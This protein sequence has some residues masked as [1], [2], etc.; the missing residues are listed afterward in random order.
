MRLQASTTA[1]LVGNNDFHTDM[2]HA[3]PAAGGM[4]DAALAASISPWQR[5]LRRG[6]ATPPTHR[7]PAPPPPPPPALRQPPRVSCGGGPGTPAQAEARSRP[8]GGTLRAP[9]RTRTAPGSQSRPRSPHRSPR[10]AGRGEEGESCCEDKQ[11]RKKGVRAVWKQG[12][13]G[14]RRTRLTAVAAAAIAG[15]PPAH[16]RHKVLLRSQGPGRRRRLLLQL[17]PLVPCR[18]RQQ[19]QQPLGTSRSPPHMVAGAAAQPPPAAS[20]AASPAASHSRH[21]VPCRRCCM[22]KRAQA[23][24][25]TQTQHAPPQASL[26]RN[27]SPCPAPAR[28]PP[29]EQAL[30]SAASQPRSEA[31]LSAYLSRLCILSARHL[32]Y[33]NLRGGTG[34][35][36]GG[37]AVQGWVGGRYRLAGR[38]AGQV[39]RQA[40]YWA[41]QAANRVWLSGKVGGGSSRQVGVASQGRS[42]EV[43]LAHPGRRPA[44]S[45]QSSCLGWKCWAHRMWRLYLPSAAV[46]AWGG[47][48]FQQHVQRKQTS[49]AD[50]TTGNGKQAKRPCPGTGGRAQRRVQPQAPLQRLTWAVLVGKA[51]VAGVLHIAER[52]VT[53]MAAGQQTISRGAQATAGA[54]RCAL[55]LPSYP[56]PLSQPLD[57][58][59]AL[60]L[61]HVRPISFATP[62]SNSGCST[63]LTMCWQ[64]GHLHRGRVMGEGGKNEGGED[65]NLLGSAAGCLQAPAARRL[66]AGK[67]SRGAGRGSA[68]ESGLAPTHRLSP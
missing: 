64:S 66:L 38:Q 52:I 65:G 39:G 1:K 25:N 56:P 13:W 68:A 2:K 33:G 58:C 37:R 22:Y 48:A 26:P 41:A 49:R 45:H 42:R 9:R 51:S 62:L 60:H 61:S 28:H 40:V 14:S 35:Q 29:S 54:R 46:Q 6:G 59:P 57:P 30:T 18:A 47:R 44:T 5:R 7:T 8:W 31:H 53:A 63:S 24:P 34:R 3:A 43:R 19:K 21:Q 4:L 50:K 32:T 16:P 20:R 10:S 23:H 11:P 15:A 67:W 17:L 36:A 12:C 27:R 55:P